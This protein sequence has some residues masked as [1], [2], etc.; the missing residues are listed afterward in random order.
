MEHLIHLEKKVY[1]ERR[2]TLWSQLEQDSVIVFPAASVKVRNRDVEY[3]YRQE[4]NFY[5]LSG[6]EEPESVLVLRYYKGNPQS[7]LFLREREPKQER[8]EGSRLGVM[9]AAD[10]L[11]IDEAY[12]IEELEKKLL[13][14]FSSCRH[15]YIDF[16]VDQKWIDLIFS[17]IANL[18]RENRKESLGP[19]GL[20]DISQ[21]VSLLRKKKDIGEIEL[22]KKAA[23]IS[24]EAHLSAMRLVAPG[25]F[26]YEIK[27]AFEHACL[28][29]GAKRMA[30]PS[31][32]ASGPNAC[33]LHYRGGE[34]QMK[35]GDL[36]LLDGGCEYGYY[37]SDITR[38]YPVDGRWKGEQKRLYELVLEAQKA[39]IKKVKPGVSLEELH[40]NAVSILSRGLCEE[41]IITSSYHEVIDHKLYRRYFM[42]GTSHFL[43]VDVH[44]VGYDSTSTVLEAGHVITV[45][46]G[47]YI[48]PD[49]DVDSRWK[50]IGIRIEDDILVKK[51][52][53]E[54]LSEDIPKEVNDLEAAFDFR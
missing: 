38:T 29:R 43:G 7:I 16:G 35:A 34:R 18:H 10:V 3:V 52:G 17:I 13:D 15:I 27:A 31:I 8:W 28:Q 32:V 54:N 40:Q 50:G 45:E 33:I 4:S 47:L 41:G 37:A 26:E 6:F 2:N 44:D 1:Q 49:A 9:K 24:K 22:M 25:I 39:V 46:P 51:E 20:M 23:S 30:Y 11:G 36:L 48:S 12:C 5:Y 14:Y 42:H 21:A 53:S 19:C